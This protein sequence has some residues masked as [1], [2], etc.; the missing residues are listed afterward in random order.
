MSVPVPCNQLHN[1]RTTGPT[2]ATNPH[3]ISRP[4]DPPTATT[5]AE[6]G[7]RCI[8]T[9]MRQGRRRHGRDTYDH[10]GALEQFRLIR[11]GC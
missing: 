3:R 5:P 11:S 10:L 8:A 4:A 7:G 2:P 1:L 6:T 9:F